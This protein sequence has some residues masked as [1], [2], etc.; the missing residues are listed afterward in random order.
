MREYVR[1]IT[2]LFSR[3][4]PAVA[5]ASAL[6]LTLPTSPADAAGVR[7][8]ALGDSYSAGVG[9]YDKQN[10]CYQSPK[11]FP[12]LT[13][14]A[15]GWTLNYQ[16]CSGATSSQVLS[17]QVPTIS[18]DTS[19]VTVTAG[20][21][22]AGFNNAMTQCALPGWLG[23]CAQAVSAA[24]Q[25]IT[26]VLPARLASVY[27]G[28][29]AQAPGATVFAVGYPR[30]FNGIDCSLLT[31]FTGSEMSALNQAADTMASVTSQ[32]ASANGATFVDARPAFAAHEVCSASPWINNLSL[33]TAESFHPNV[34]GNVAY[35]QLVLAATGSTSRLTVPAVAA[36]APTDAQVLAAASRF[37]SL[38]S[39][40][41]LARGHRAGFSTPTLTSINSDLHSGNAQRA[42]RAFQRLHQLDAGR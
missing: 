24:N 1:M 34:A 8:T 4:V 33:V 19:V 10:A 12:V 37:P 30:L 21:N 16:A 23:N 20:G 35:E 17:T 22:D 3:L 29:R 27:A 38:V 7:Y 31:F 28:I 25:T 14:S 18:G 32:A 40:T 13:A 42:R 41:S 15:K 9:T 2:R 11:G 5:V 6:V 26:T 36:S 39:V